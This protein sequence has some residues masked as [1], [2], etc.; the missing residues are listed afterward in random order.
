MLRLLSDGASDPQLPST[1]KLELL[2]PL[3][4][5]LQLKDTSFDPTGVV[6]TSSSRCTMACDKFIQ[7]VQILMGA[8][9]IAVFLSFFRNFHFVEDRKA[10][11]LTSAGFVK[12]DVYR[13]LLLLTKAQKSSPSSCPQCPPLIWPG[14]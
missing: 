10:E 3:V 12:V 5:V 14:A 13:G 7:M 4:D 11:L 2:A 8:H 6:E 1:A 9:D